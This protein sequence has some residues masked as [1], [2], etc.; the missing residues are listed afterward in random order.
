MT[1]MYSEIDR[2]HQPTLTQAMNTERFDT[3]MG[4]KGK[5]SEE[6]E[7]KTDFSITKRSKFGVKDQKPM[8]EGD[9]DDTLVVIEEEDKKNEGEE[10]KEKSEKTS[11]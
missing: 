8:Y 4:S 2:L 11:H 3:D 1:I 6:T 10:Q 9:N 5:P 7:L